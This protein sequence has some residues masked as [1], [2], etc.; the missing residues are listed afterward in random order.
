MNIAILASAEDA[1]TIPAILKTF[2]AI[3]IDAFGLKFKPEWVNESR[4]KI[5]SYLLKATHILIIFSHFSESSKWF[6]FLAGFCHAHGRN[7]SLYGTNTD[8]S[9][10]PYIGNVPFI[11]SLYDLKVYFEK[12]KMEWHIY[13]KRRTARTTLLE[14]GISFHADAMF[15][16]IASGNLDVVRLFILGGF[17][18][19]LRDRNGVPILNLAVRAKQ[20]DIVKELVMCGAD[21]NMQSEDR[22]FSPLMDSVK[23]GKSEIIDYFLSINVDTNIISKDGQTAIIIAVGR[24]DVET[25]QK[26]LKAG[27][28]P[29]I[30]DK[31]GQ[32]A[33]NY[34]R[35]F[36][37]PQMSELFLNY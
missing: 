14:M 23:T 13:E 9:I 26:L 10:P 33:R 34:A 35:L 21:P 2:E 15:Q 25:T 36:N 28:N 3:N 22:G 1:K 32:S 29:D 17:N 16:A 24:K 5:D 8:T 19:C 37:N 18:P 27:A 4:V 6:P 20:L 31:L 11:T 12:E 30:V 7:L